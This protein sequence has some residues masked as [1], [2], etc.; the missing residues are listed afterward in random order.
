MATAGQDCVVQTPQPRTQK[1]TKT[2]NGFVENAHFC[3]FKAKTSARH[4]QNP[5]QGFPP[6]SWW[7]NLPQDP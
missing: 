6:G 5:E 1:R 2:G 3:W 4:G 7:V